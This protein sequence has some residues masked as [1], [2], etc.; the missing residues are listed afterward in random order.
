MNSRPKRIRWGWIVVVIL[1]LVLEG[2]HS[3]PHLNAM[4]NFESHDEAAL[5]ATLIAMPM[6]QLRGMAYG[7]FREGQ[8][9]ERGVYPT[10]SEVRQDMPLL[11][12]V[13][14]GIRTYGCRHL[15]TVITATREVSLPLTL[16]I[17][18]SG[19]SEEDRA[20]IECA[21]SQ[22]QAN[23]HIA[24][25]VVGNES[26]LSGWLTVTQVCSY[27]LEVQE[28]TGLPV[29]TAEPWHVWVNN[30]NLAACV[31][32]LLI[33]IHPYWECQPIENAVAFVQE[34]Y[35]QVSTQYADKVVI[36]GETGWPTAGTGREDHCGSMPAPSPEQQSLFA[37]DF[38]NWAEQEGV[39]FYY[40][41]AFDEP[42]K[43]EGERPEV[44][45]HWGI[46]DTDRVP[47]P[48]RDLFVSHRLCLPLVVSHYLPPP[49][50]RVQITS[51][52]DGARV[53]ADSAEAITV[54]GRVDNV[55]STGWYLTFSVFSPYLN[56]WFPQE[57]V[58]AS[59]YPSGTWQAYP[60]YLKYS[61]TNHGIEVVLHNTSGNTIA[62]DYVEVVK[63]AAAL[64]APV[65]KDH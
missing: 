50:P 34:K 46:Y 30:P 3:W 54:T 36:I 49:V 27:T 11:K 9:P 19:N 61:P 14:N 41:G 4:S 17:W 38:L 24:S 21:V 47:K 51:P 63:V 22:V 12:L 42:W 6:G 44:E 60:I 62:A 13:A 8:S 32:Y 20:E 59:P 57:L 48:A 52:I 45:C 5:T 2:Q 29:I 37:A 16:G 56:R 39:E 23:P 40:F 43:C 33:H 15:E 25:I 26:I 58:I 18:L 53:V 1:I 55:A 35:E 64:A 65:L 7:P 31:D 10:L 28:R